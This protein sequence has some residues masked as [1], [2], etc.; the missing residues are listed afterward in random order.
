ML[1]QSP[2]PLHPALATVTTFAVAQVRY[3]SYCPFCSTHKSTPLVYWWGCYGRGVLFV[4][5]LRL[6]HCGCPPH[7]Q[8]Q[9]QWAQEE[10]FAQEKK[11]EAEKEGRRKKEKKEPPQNP[12]TD[13]PFA[14]ITFRQTVCST[15]RKQKALSPLRYAPFRSHLSLAE[16][17]RPTQKEKQKLSNVII[18]CRANVSHMVRNTVI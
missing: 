1:R 15:P 16:P 10:R 9:P 13:K 3:R 4:V 8:P 14:C 5:C 2:N 17:T 7:P 11:E 6:R 18:R 12:C